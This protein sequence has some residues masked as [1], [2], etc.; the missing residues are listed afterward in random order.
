MAMKKIVTLA[1]VGVF[2]LS[3]Q[4]ASLA[5]EKEKAPA[6]PAVPPAVEKAPAAPEVKAP[7]APAKKEEAKATKKAKKAEKKKAKKAKAKKKKKA[8]AEE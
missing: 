3:L 4:G 5:Q 6:P 1:S 7:A 8:K 2:L